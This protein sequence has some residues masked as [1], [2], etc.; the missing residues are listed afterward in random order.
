MKQYKAI[1]KNGKSE[2]CD[3]YDAET[4]DEARILWEKDRKEFGLPETVTVEIDE[5]AKLIPKK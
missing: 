4:I 3:W 2:Y 5:V 1:T